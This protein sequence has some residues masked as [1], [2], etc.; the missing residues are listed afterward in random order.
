MATLPPEELAY[1]QAH[2]DEDASGSLIAFYAVCIAL[3]FLCAVSRTTSRR[4]SSLGLQA[5]DWTL[6]VGAV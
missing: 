5:D 2:R 3:T 6:L 4:L 1:Q